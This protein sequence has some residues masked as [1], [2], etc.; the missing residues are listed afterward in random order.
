MGSVNT[1]DPSNGLYYD[2]M[3]VSMSLCS[4]YNMTPF[5]LFAQNTEEVIMIVNFYIEKSQYNTVNA[6][7]V[8]KNNKEERIRVTE[9]TAT[10]GWY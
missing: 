10:G 1:T 9:K 8:K 5:Y 2:L 7:K 4:N 6:S 3:Y